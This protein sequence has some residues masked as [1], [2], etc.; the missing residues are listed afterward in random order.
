MDAVTCVQ[1]TW[2]GRIIMA[3][4]N[5]PRDTRKASKV[6]AC[7]FAADDIAIIHFGHHDYAQNDG[8][9]VK[10]IEPVSREVLD[11]GDSRQC[12]GEPLY[13]IQRLG[14]PLR[15]SW[16][17]E[18]NEALYAFESALHLIGHMPEED[19]DDDDDPDPML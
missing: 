4:S 18:G 7:K 12:S 11:R 14:R 6:T 16:H 15:S 3:K 1:P 19:D 2:E 8:A 13:W 9:V 17:D 5:A 10:I